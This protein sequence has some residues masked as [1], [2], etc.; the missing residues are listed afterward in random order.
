MHQKTM[1][2]NTLYTYFVSYAILRM[3]INVHKNIDECNICKL[4]LY[5]SFRLHGTIL[6]LRTTEDL[7]F[8]IHASH[9]LAGICRV[10]NT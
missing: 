9:N 2:R 4:S 10:R 5:M 7:A 8:L 1:S 6:H 3:R